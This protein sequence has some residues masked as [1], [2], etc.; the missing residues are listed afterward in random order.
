[1]PQ[2]L[3]YVLLIFGLFILPRFLQR[4]G[5]PGAV[6]S[7]CLGFVSTQIEFLP[8]DHTIALLSTFGIVALFLWAGL[9]IDLADLR[10]AWRALTSHLVVFSLL[11]AGTSWL[12]ARWV[13]LEVRAATILALALVT[14]STG[15]ILDSL[16]AFGLSRAE[17]RRVRATAIATEIVALLALF[18]LTQGESWLR[19]AGSSLAL[20]ALVLAIPPVLRVFA[21]HIEPYAPRTEFAFLMMVAVV[22]AYATRKL[23]V[24]YLLGAFLVGLTARRF[25]D[26]FPAMS[27]D[28]LLNT[29]EE[30]ALV[31]GPFY[32]FHAGQELRSSDFGFASVGLGLVLA[33]VLLPLR[34]CQVAA[35]QGRRAEWT[36]RARLRV[37]TA[38]LPTLVISIVLLGI[39]R[40][41]FAFEGPLVGALM[42]YTLASTVLP[43]FL[44][45]LQPSAQASTPVP[46]TESTREAA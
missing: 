34:A 5:L 9:E 33:L 8:H 17:I 13:G 40:E 30:F 4:Y 21:R 15:F 38:L 3:C 7:L 20:T 25:R 41:R 18:A 29:V 6:T 32:F 28:R 12:L 27:S 43:G 23:G 24:Y 22:C 46:A 42:V 2:D 37:G 10:P 39:L 31:F 36:W 16:A 44:L 26:Q 45:R 19:F 1:M 35:L 14:P 11:L